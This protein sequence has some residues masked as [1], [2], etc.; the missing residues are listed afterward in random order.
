MTHKQ[1]PEPWVRNPQ[2]WENFKKRIAQKED[3]E[4]VEKK[5]VL[6]DGKEYTCECIEKDGH[7]FVK[8]RS[9]SQA[10]Y[11]VVFD[12]AR[13]LPAMTAPQCRAF[14]PDGDEAV[15]DAIV[16]LRGTCGLEEQTIAYMRKYQY[17]DDLVKKLAV[18]VK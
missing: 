5:T 6:V 1:C 7:N 11:D 12:A 8:M 13:Q 15:Q 14:V 2:L 17:G 10:G 16:T 4:V 9:L 18:A 3:D